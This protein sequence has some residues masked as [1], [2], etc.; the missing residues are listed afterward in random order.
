LRHSDVPGVRAG[1]ID[2]EVFEGA[3]RAVEAAGRILVTS[4][5]R[6][7]G[8]ALGCAIALREVLRGLGKRVLAGIPD[9]VPG[10]YSFLA[11]SEPLANL[12]RQPEFLNDFGADLVIIA[13]TSSTAQ[14]GP[15]WPHLQK[16]PA[17][18]LIV[19]HHVTHDVPA[20]TELYD[21]TAGA[22]ALVLLE[23]FSAAGWKVDRT[24]GEALFVAIATDTGWF[25]FP[26][27]DARMYRTAAGLIE[28]YGVRPHELYEKMYMQESPGRAR[29]L[30]AMLSSLE[31]HADDQLAAC[32]ITQETFTRCGAQYWETED[33]INEPMRIG[34]VRVTALFIEEPD[35]KVRVSLR[36]KDTVNVA[37]VAEAF[38]GGGHERAAGAR[39][40]GPLEAAKAAVTAAVVA[41]LGA[42]KESR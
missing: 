7:D 16:C 24:A 42:G 5:W 28:K 39:M 29:L 41:A 31:L 2:R 30:G 18:R 26:N 1:R 17:P 19:D 37:A 23:W 33:L 15:I 3:T 22:T 25:R 12:A 34:S 13:D 38:G 6:P 10:R 8:D 35:G 9:D 21:A 20:A 11:E 32:T 40:A 4:H 27:T 14:L 36:S